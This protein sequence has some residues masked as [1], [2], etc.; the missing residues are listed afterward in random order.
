[1]CFSATVSYS[2]ATVLV[3]T[4]LYAVHQARRL[5]LPYWLL[6]LVPLLF[7]VQQVFEGRVWQELNGGSGAVA[8]PYAIGFLFFSHFLWL[9]WFPLCSYL[10][11]RDRFRRRLFLGLL[12]FGTFAGTVVFFSI[13]FNPDW[14][15]VSVR[16]HSIIYGVESGYRSSISIPLPASV[17]YAMV[18]LVPLVFSS[19]SHL[20]VFG[21]LAALSMGFASVFYNYALVSVWCL[22]A[23][24]LSL[25]LAYM[26]IRVLQ[27]TR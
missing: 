26:I 10:L 21:L 19:H 16:K 4:G 25:Y 18:I 27:Q 15:T 22:F 3:A 17:L 20:R 12:L 14:V 11:E 8:V 5:A 9:W 6:A 7:G 1:M 2:A 24:V 23:A 13:L